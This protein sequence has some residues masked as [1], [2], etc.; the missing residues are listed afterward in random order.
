MIEG[1]MAHVYSIETGG[2][3][4]LVDT[5]TKG[6]SKKIVSYYDQLGKGPDY[7][8]ITHYHMD[9]IGGLQSIMD[10][11]SSEIYAPASEIDIIAGRKGMPEGTPAFLKLFTRVPTVSN[12]ERIKPSTDISIDG[13]KVVETF[14][15]TPGS[16]SYLFTKSSSLCV[17]DALYN[18]RGTLAVNRM[19]SLDM[20]KAS[21]SK[22]KILSMRPLMVLPGHGDPI[23]I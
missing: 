5:G 18:K 17:G 9:H 22:E 13:V 11:F 19:F 6:S 16:T 1:T 15:H 21:G 7:V 12:P 2:K 20:E 3:T 23:R 10:N 4:V 14:G 8:L